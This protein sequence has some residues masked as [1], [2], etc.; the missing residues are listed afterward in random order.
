MILSSFGIWFLII[1]ALFDISVL[2]AVGKSFAAK[3]GINDLCK[4][5]RVLMPSSLD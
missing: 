5:K 4:K 2:K 1:W 3:K